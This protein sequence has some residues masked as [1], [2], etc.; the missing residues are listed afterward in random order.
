MSVVKRLTHSLGVLTGITDGSRVAINAGRLAS[1]QI[2]D[3]TDILHKSRDDNTKQELFANMVAKMRLTEADLDR[4]R[5][6][7]VWRARVY[8]FL[9]LF[10]LSLGMY[11]FIVIGINGALICF[12]IVVVFAGLTVRAYFQAWQIKRRRFAKLDEF[13]RQRLQAIY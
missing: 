11:Q 10:C 6:Q 13:I 12:G 5:W 9:A 8:L 1:Q 4:R 3:V 2:R 7:L